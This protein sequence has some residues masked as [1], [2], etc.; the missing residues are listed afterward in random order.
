MFYRRRER[1]TDAVAIYDKLIVAKPDAANAHL[2]L[3]DVSVN[4]LTAYDRGGNELRIWLANPPADGSGTNGS[5]A[6]FLL[7]VVQQ[8]SGHPDLAKKEYQIAIVA[9]PKNEDAKK[10]LASL[11]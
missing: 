5:L 1:W 3:G 11:K 8:Q 9:N 2:K 10:A 4:N 6:H 7:G